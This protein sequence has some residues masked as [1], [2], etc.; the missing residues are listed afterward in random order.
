MID[1]LPWRKA[2]EQIKS[3]PHGQSDQHCQQWQ[4]QDRVSRQAGHGVTIQPFADAQ[5]SRA[6]CPALS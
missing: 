2:I 1:T 3:A 5:G 6:R 4:D